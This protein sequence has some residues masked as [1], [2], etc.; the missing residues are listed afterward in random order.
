MHELTYELLFY[1]TTNTSIYSLSTFPSQ[2]NMYC[3]VC[4]YKNSITHTPPPFAGVIKR[5]LLLKNPPETLFNVRSTF[6]LHKVKSQVIAQRAYA[7]IKIYNIIDFLLV[8]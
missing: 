5:L 4:T 1:T 3:V 7:Y 2:T 6:F 8:P